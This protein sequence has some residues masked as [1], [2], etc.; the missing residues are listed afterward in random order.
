MHLLEREA[1]LSE[2]EAHLDAVANGT[3][4]LVLLGG[5]AGVG[6]SVLVRAFCDRVRGRT[7]VLRG[8]CDPLSTP[9]PLGPLLEIADALDASL[10]DLLATSAPRQRIFEAAR[11]RLSAQGQP[12]LVV[13]EDVHWADEATLDLLRYLG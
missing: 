6:K 9:T 4:R 2:L 3:G 8:A 7:R 1:Q 12:A 11:A 10:A 5:E 13:L